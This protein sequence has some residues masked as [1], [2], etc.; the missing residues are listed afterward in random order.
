MEDWT[1]DEANRTV[2]SLQTRLF[3]ILVVYGVGSAA[4][5]GGH[6][7]QRTWVLTVPL[8]LASVNRVAGGQ[9]RAVGAR[10]TT[11]AARLTLLQGTFGE[12]KIDWEGSAIQSPGARTSFPESRHSTGR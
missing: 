12:T 11:I 10:A 7:R 1:N 8:L 3:M 2:E 4:P 9:A 5:P 6:R